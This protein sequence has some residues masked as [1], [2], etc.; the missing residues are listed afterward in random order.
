M[1]FRQG[2]DEEA[3]GIEDKLSGLR[4][5]EE[6][7][8]LRSKELQEKQGFANISAFKVYSDTQFIFALIICAKK[9]NCFRDGKYWANFA[10][11]SAAWSFSAQTLSDPLPPL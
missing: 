8:S 9:S 7:A 5:E 11:Q 2:K 10:L 6:E 3:E 1:E 4:E